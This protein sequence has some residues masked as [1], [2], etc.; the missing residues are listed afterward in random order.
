MLELVNLGTLR[1]FQD[2]ITILEGAWPQVAEPT[3]DSV[4]EVLVHENLAN[5]LGLQVGE[6]YTLYNE[7][8]ESDTTLRFVFPVRISGI[9][10]AIS[11]EE[12]FW[13][14]SVDEFEK[15]FAVPE[16]TYMG[17][18]VPFMNN[19]VNL[20]LW[21][22]V[23]DGSK[24]HSSDIPSMLSRVASARQKA[25]NLL[26]DVRLD[27]SPIES[28][29]AFYR[30]TSTLTVFL[31]AISVPI[32]LLILVFISLVVDMAVAR[33]Q[34][35]IAVLRS[36][37]AT[38]LQIIG[39]A[40]LEGSLLGVVGL[41]AGIPTSQGVSQFLGKTRSFLD[42]TANINLPTAI[43]RTALLFGFGIAVIGIFA[44][45]VPSFSAARHTIITYKQESAAGARCARPGGSAPGCDLML[46]VPAAYGAYLLRTQGGGALADPFK[47]RCCCWCQH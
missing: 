22:M 4:I 33:R 9:W 43:T 46:L 25:L 19:R 24:L 10:T 6:D 37:G 36:R 41:A 34:N 29:S 45:L 16:E 12:P 32:L 2:H 3:S 35:E 42:F 8:D 21:Y 40:G 38:T 47:I 20:A 14:Y 23:F 39:M 31:Y 7:I 13:F 17:R 5:R 30:A 44:Q 1:G 26:Q 11:P 28:L 27:V 15:L 18:V